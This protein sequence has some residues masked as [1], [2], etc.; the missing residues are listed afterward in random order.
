MGWFKQI[1][2]M[3]KQKTTV[4]S[5]CAST[6]GPFA[7]E[8]TGIRSSPYFIK[9]E[10]CQTK[11]PLVSFASTV[12]HSPSK[13]IFKDFFYECPKCG[14]LFYRKIPYA[15]TRFGV[16]GCPNCRHS[17]P[18][19]EDI[20]YPESSKTHRAVMNNASG[21]DSPEELEP[22]YE[23]LVAN[24]PKLSKTIENVMLVKTANYHDIWVVCKGADMDI[25]SSLRPFL[26]AFVDHKLTFGATR[27]WKFARKEKGLTIIRQMKES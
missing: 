11:F 2:K 19:M 17:F 9:C 1:L 8:E 12:G 21:P 23:N 27:R 20:E 3:R 22:L 15:Y 7:Q 10:S 26:M 25:E 5:I 14:I 13:S 6:E 4:C 16:S 18:S 24:K